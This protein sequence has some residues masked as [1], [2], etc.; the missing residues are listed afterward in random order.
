MPNVTVIR[1]HTDV[2]LAIFGTSYVTVEGPQKIQQNGSSTA[3]ALGGISLFSGSSLDLIA[4]A[5]VSYNVGAGITVSGNATLSLLGSTISNNTEEGVSVSRMS[6]AQLLGPNEPFGGVNNILGNGIADISCDRTS[7]V[8]G[9]LSGV[10]NI[11]CKRVDRELGP[12]R[13]GF[14]LPPKP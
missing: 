7:L 5:E 1:G 10:A 6:L 3:S 8:A 11:Q 4:G 9:D 12:P 14:I 13:P 2:G